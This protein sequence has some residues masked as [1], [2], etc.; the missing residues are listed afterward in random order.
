MQF[1][2]ASPQEDE[3]NNSHY[4]TE[5]YQNDDTVPEGQ[6][7]FEGKGRDRQLIAGELIFQLVT[8]ETDETVLDGRDVLEPKQPHW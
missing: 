6:L 2:S 7:V 3:S 1:G 8:H 4:N 5:G